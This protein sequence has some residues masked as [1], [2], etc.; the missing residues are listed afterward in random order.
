LT[1]D[2]RRITLRL[3]MGALVIAAL[4]GLGGWL[5]AGSESGRLLVIVSL[6]MFA[7]TYYVLETQFSGR[8]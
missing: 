1:D 3:C 8:A 5:G 4:T 2:K 6:L 7:L